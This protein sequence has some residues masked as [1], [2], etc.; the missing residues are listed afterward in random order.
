M[1]H[2]AGRMGGPV[3]SE[4][5]HGECP[6]VLSTCESQVPSAGNTHPP[7]TASPPGVQGTTAGTGFSPR[8]LVSV[9]AM[10]LKAPKGLGAGGHRAPSHSQPFRCLRPADQLLSAHLE[11]VTVAWKLMCPPGHARL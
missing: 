6:M 1:W 7:P 3:A 5:G 8:S 2:W 11:G 10:V 4:S 9:L